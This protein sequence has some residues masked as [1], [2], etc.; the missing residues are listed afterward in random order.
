[1]N[2]L[3]DRRKKKTAMYVQ[4]KQEIEK[5]L[6]TKKVQVILVSPILVHS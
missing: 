4:Y 3:T 1:M 6:W 2:Y 5:K